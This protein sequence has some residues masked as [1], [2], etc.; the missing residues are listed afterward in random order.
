MNRKQKRTLLLLAAAAAVLLAVLLAVRAANSR[1][2]QQEAEAAAAAAASGVITDPAASYRE[3]SYFNGSATLSF[4]LDEDGNWYWKDDA[5]FPLDQS[6]L[7]KMVNTLSALKPQQTITD[8]DTLEAYGLAEPG[9]TLAAIAGNGMTTT[10]ALGNTT[11]D[12]DSYYM[13]MNGA[14]TPVYII[15]DELARE[16]DVS[17]YD[18][19]VLPELSLPSEDQLT[20]VNISGAADVT[21]TA[22][23]GEAGEDGKTPVTWR[24]GGA[25]VTDDE[26]VRSILDQILSL[27]LDGCA[28]YRPSDGAA[29]LCGFDEP[30]AVVTV[31]YTSGGA[32]ETLTLTVGAR[33]L[34]G[35]GRYVRV[36]DDETIYR[37]SADRLDAVMRAAANGLNGDA[38]AADGA[39]G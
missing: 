14:Q 37:M 25:N 23:R 27:K 7:T 5:D 35:D 16:M 34:D 21:L 26:Q 39:E 12:G 3:L 31:R 4:A 33:L 17:I 32:V 15:S 10:L 9:R 2:Q 28:D 29:S 8:G 36:N 6:Y 1:R 13:L 20:S 24:S 11:T 30:D 19:C 18:M 22:I 38:P